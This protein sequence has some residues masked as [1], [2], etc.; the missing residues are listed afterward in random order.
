MRLVDQLKATARLV[1]VGLGLVAA[2]AAQGQLVSGPDIV[3]DNIQDI[4]NYGAG[5]GGI[6]GY[7]IGS[8]TCNIGNT[9]LAW[10]NNGTPGL[11][12]NAYRLHNGR[13]MQ[14]GMSWVKLACCVANGGGCTSMSGQTLTCGSGFGL[15]PG[16][17]DVY[18]ASWN[19]GQSR[20]AQRSSINPF[21]R[22]FGA[23]NSGSGDAAFKRLQIAPGDIGLAG[24]QYYAE[25]VYVC[26]DENPN[27][28]WNNATY[29]PVTFSGTNMAVTGT[30]Q[31]GMPAIKAWEAA[32]PT[33]V[34]K[35]ANAPSEGIYYFAAKTVNLAAGWTRYEY[36]VFNLNSHIAGGSYRIPLPPGAQI[37]NIGFSAPPYHSGEVYSNAPWVADIDSC[38]INFRSPQ[39]FAQNANA[40]ALRWGTMYNFWFEATAAPG[41]GSNTLG[42]FRPHSPSS[43]SSGS[44][45]VPTT[46][47][48]AGDW[49]RDGVV[50]FNDF[51][52]FLNDFNLFNSCADL[53]GDGVV[54]FNDLLEFLNDFNTPCP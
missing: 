3:H 50:D 54:D 27:N 29:R 44:L 43:M 22:T 6:L 4:A 32:D 1:A 26:T 2:G 13:L 19:G 18:S 28:V 25:G 7:A 41:S 9:S 31:M 8:N 36:A 38:S 12:M 51:L 37:R 5:A 40:N 16:C 24:A 17:K 53:N 30:R 14:I 15:R 35:T 52:D 11:A 33:V 47:V 34:V 23:Y 46:A 39:T 49:N 48:C 10:N 21:A 20:L 45:P 42:F